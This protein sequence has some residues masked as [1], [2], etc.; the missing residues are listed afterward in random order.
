MPL[1]TLSSTDDGV[2]SRALTSEPLTIGRHPDVRWRARERDIATHARKQRGLLDAAA[3]L[4]R[5]GGTLVYATCS[6]EPE[7]NEQIVARFRARHADYDEAPPLEWARPFVRDGFLRTLPEHDP[8]DAF[9]A[10]TMKRRD[11]P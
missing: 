10:A 7:E 1:F 6:T 8:G 3:R 9:F 2:G 4:V 11:Q 5:P